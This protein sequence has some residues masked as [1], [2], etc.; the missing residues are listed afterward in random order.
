[1]A[2]HY[3]R[4][5]PEPG[6]PFAYFQWNYGRGVWEQSLK[7]AHPRN[8]VVAAYALPSSDYRADR[9]DE[10]GR[11]RYVASGSGYVMARR[12]GAA[13]RVLPEEVWLALPLHEAAT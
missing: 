12:P 5:T 6:K 3:P 2:E 8:D 13:P 9:A 7:R 4:P 11:L 1:M 10:H